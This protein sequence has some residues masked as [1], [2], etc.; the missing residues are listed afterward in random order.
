[1]S[2]DNNMPAEI[3]ETFVSE[4]KEYLEDIEKSLLSFEENPQ[5]LGLINNIFR[6]I[7]TIK[8][9]A[10]AC[11]FTKLA[12]LVHHAETLLSLL[13][14]QKIKI[15]SRIIDALL[16]SFDAISS[17][18]DHVENSNQMDIDIFVKNLHEHMKEIGDK[19]E[20]SGGLHLFSEE[21]QEPVVSEK[22]AHL[23]MKKTSS[24]HSETIRIKVSSLD[25][26]IRLVG[27][28]VL[29]RNQQLRMTDNT[30][31]IAYAAA[32]K[33]DLVTSEIQEQIMSTRMQ[34]LSNVF[35][36]LSRVVRD[37]SRRLEK[38][39]KLSISGEDVEIDKTILEALADP[40]VHIIR[41]SCDHAI[42][43]PYERCQIQKD[44]TG[45]ISIHAFHESG[46]V[47]IKIEDDGRGIDTKILKKQALLKNLKTKEALSKMT[48]KDLLNLVFLPSVSTA[49]RVSDVSGRGVGMDV[50]RTSVEG[51]GGTID[52][53]SELGKG[54]TL[55]FRLPLTLAIIP[56]L[57]VT[58]DDQRF[59]IPQV[60]LE[61]LV[62]LYDE[63]VREKIEYAGNKEVYRLR[64]QL[65]SLVRLSEVLKHPMPFNEQRRAEIMRSFQEQQRQL[66]EQEKN[67]GEQVSQS[68]TLAVLK[69]GR[70]RFGLII[71][72]I[73]GTEEV[74]VTSMHPAIKETKIYSGATVMGDGKVSL[75]LDI[76]GI[77]KYAGINS[78][79]E[80]KKLDPKPASRQNLESL[81]VFKSGVKEQF[82]IK[83]SKIKRIERIHMEKVEYVGEKK[84][85]TI[86]HVS[87]LL[88][89][90]NDQL[91]VSPFVEKKDMFFIL[92]KVSV[93]PYGILASS[94][95]DIGE[96]PVR[97][98][99]ESYREPGVLGSIILNGSMTLMLDIETVIRQSEP[100]WFSEPHSLEVS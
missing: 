27:E 59:A 43:S 25:A 54:T 16:K 65:L 96:Y 20:S 55:H 17:M 95:I 75:I 2:V 39:I 62:C 28:L 38:K 44:E 100:S 79:T 19:K 74:V 29:I 15:N 73:I 81:L 49:K 36:K 10:G 94:L 68:L 82:S 89:C 21:D 93:R 83:L 46:Q 1:M 34:P 66:L 18:V 6:A 8:G 76:L 98:D 64:K 97:F 63:E 70:L 87:T 31:S 9:S 7:H 56:C 86:N 57:I 3:I 51:L 72:S 61:E 33:L 58:V 12:E 4:S 69:A 53:H 77:A 67:S 85:I 30:N 84:F 92:P 99:V 48:E 11:G 41:N 24:A 50:V 91:T 13:R 71:D 37:L 32:Q 42:E 35:A 40:L 78:E 80:A 26:L 22:S 47:N 45:V 5:D 60:N 88:I 14:E 90:L 23:P 52:I